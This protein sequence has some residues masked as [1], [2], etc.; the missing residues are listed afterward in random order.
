MSY[1]FEVDG[2]VK[3]FGKTTA[4]AAVDLRASPG[5]VLGVLGPNGRRGRVAG[6]LVGDPGVHFLDEP[7]TGL[8]PAARG[9]VGHDPFA[10]GGRGD[11]PAHDAVPRGGR[12]ARR[13]DRGDQRRPGHRA[14]HPGRA[15]ATGRRPDGRCAPEGP[16]HARPGRRGPSPDDRQRDRACAR[17]RADRPDRRRA[18]LRRGRARPGGGRA[19]C[20]FDEA[21][22]THP[23]YSGLPTCVAHPAAPGLD[24]G[25]LC[26]V[27]PSP[28]EPAAFRAEPPMRPPRDPHARACRG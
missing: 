28:G 14:R 6:S 18:R 27:S 11:R 13:R 7:T 25:Q 22:P 12:R 9:P 19:A 24:R 23:R 3:R 15:Q 5:T 1:A 2:L 4:L 10:G 20:K 8:D 16:G 21:G 26:P 17:R